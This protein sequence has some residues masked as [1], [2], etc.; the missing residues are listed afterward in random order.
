MDANFTAGPWS[1]EGFEQISGNGNF[2]GGLI[3]GADG[4]TIVAQCVMPHNAPLVKAAP[5][6]FKALSRLLKSH[7][8]TKLP[9]QPKSD[10]E[11]F[12]EEVLAKVSG[13]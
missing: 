8:W 3:L 4:E 13:D 12:A 1:Q 11:K 9:G 6:L 7:Q 10:A 2:Y 5:D